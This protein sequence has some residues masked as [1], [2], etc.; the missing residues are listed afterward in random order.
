[1]GHG[2]AYSENVAHNVAGLKGFGNFTDNVG[3]EEEDVEKGLGFG[4]NEE[5]QI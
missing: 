1:L 4:L 5:I 2:V 3:I